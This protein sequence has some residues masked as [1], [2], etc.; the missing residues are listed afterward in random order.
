M[1]VSFLKM[2]DAKTTFMEEK[3]TARKSLQM[4]P[5][6]AVWSLGESAGDPQDI[7]KLALETSNVMLSSPIVHMKT[8]GDSRENSYFSSG[9]KA[10]SQS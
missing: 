4:P 7:Q 8:Y 3:I 10:K 1:V 9:T 6:A 2:A 5:L